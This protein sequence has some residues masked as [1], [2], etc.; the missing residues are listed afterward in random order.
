MTNRGVGYDWAMARIAELE[1]WQTVDLANY[2][3]HVAELT[4]ML[5]A[6]TDTAVQR[7]KLID[8][9]ELEIVR[10]STGE[11]PGDGG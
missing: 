10:W 11:W 3:R 4:E 2:K 6:A 1:R 9:L 5:T 7:G 8:E